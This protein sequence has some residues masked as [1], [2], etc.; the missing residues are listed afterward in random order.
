[1][2]VK[3]L[4]E[5]RDLA[6][7]FMDTENAE[8]D[9]ATVDLKIKGVNFSSIEDE[10]NVLWLMSSDSQRLTVVPRED[11]DFDNVT[12]ETGY[13]IPSPVIVFDSAEY[14]RLRDE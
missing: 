3:L 6:Y 13:P 9:A 5:D 11:F 12:D 1:M 8:P 4:T 10:D 2:K 7:L 14:K